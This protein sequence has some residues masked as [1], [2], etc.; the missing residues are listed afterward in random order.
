MFRLDNAEPDYAA[1][2]Y[3]NYRY[4]L[5]CALEVSN[6]Y[7]QMYTQAFCDGITLMG[8]EKKMLH[9][10]RSAWAGS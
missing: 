9:L 10:V 3:D 2:D 8:K 7:P 4:A 1:Y 5:G 6:I